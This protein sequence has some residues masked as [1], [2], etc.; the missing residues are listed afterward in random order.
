MILPTCGRPH[1]G[2]PIPLRR[3]LPQKSHPSRIPRGTGFLSGIRGPA[4]QGHR[5][6]QSRNTDPRPQEFIVRFQ[7]RPPSGLLH[8]KR[9]PSMRPIL[10]GL[11]RL[12]RP[13]IQMRQHTP[14]QPR[15]FRPTPRDRYPRPLPFAHSPCGHRSTT[16]V[17]HRDFPRQPM[18]GDPCRASPGRVH[19]HLFPAP[20]NDHLVPPTRILPWSMR[21]PRSQVQW[22]HRM[23]HRRMNAWIP[24]HRPPRFR[25]SRS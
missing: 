5:H 9:T 2:L 23:S 10:M 21:F 24:K 8:C 19:P 18:Q 12:Q 25:S 11:H 7:S 22:M 6:A 20:V 4:L 17:N 1:R 16:S 3:P 15:G 14:S 13:F